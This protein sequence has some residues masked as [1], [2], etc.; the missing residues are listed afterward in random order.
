MQNPVE[1]QK[2]VREPYETHEVSTPSKPKPK[3]SKS[4]IRLASKGR[5][6]SRSDRLSRTKKIMY[7]PGALL[8]DLSEDGEKKKN[9]FSKLCCS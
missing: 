1:V 8:E 2:L 3:K 7:K 9:W 5:N 4:L 6:V